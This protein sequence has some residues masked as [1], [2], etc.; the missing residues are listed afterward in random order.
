MDMPSWVHRIV[1]QVEVID[2]VGTL[3]RLS[4]DFTIPR[5]VNSIP[6]E[7]ALVLGNNSFVPITFLRKERLRNFDLRAP[8]GSPVPML[9]KRENGRL[10]TNI[11][12][13]QA[14]ATLGIS[15]PPS[16]LEHLR[17]VAE[18]SEH[19]EAAVSRWVQ[20]A[21]DP[22]ADDHDAWAVLTERTGFM[23]LGRALQA[24]FI[25]CAITAFTPQC[26]GILKL[27]YEEPLGE[28]RRR[29]LAWRTA[30]LAFGVPSSLA[31]SYHFELAAPPDTEVLAGGLLLESTEAGGLVPDDDFDLPRGQRLHL[32]I[33]AVPAQVAGTAFVDLR[34]RREG[35]VRASAFVGALATVLL[36]AGYLNLD[37]VTNPANSQVGA[38]LLLLAPTLLAAALVRPGE[39]RL[40]SRMLFWVRAGVIGSMLSCIAAVAS[41]AGIA[42]CNKDLVWVS[43]AGFSG[44]CAL[45]LLLACIFPRR[46]D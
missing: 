30:T 9:T 28:W 29:F 5:A 19:A 24:S 26:R 21:N 16:M 23:D 4:I 22:L 27:S 35:M 7:L 41:L 10:A 43:A 25:V 37:H 8:D 39:H 44:F 36:W 14:E 18:E 6:T 42:A 12:V 15:L 13:S 17:I 46:F 38:A 31:N 45:A 32:Y 20:F 40:A 2:D 34:V 3:R 33:R 1:E 11:L